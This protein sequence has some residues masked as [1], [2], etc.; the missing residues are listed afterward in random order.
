MQD[1]Y[2]I[3]TNSAGIPPINTILVIDDDESHHFLV[4]RNLQK[5]GCRQ[6][7]ITAQNGLDALHKLQAIAAS[8]EKLPELIFLDIR[9]PVMDG[10]EFL[11]EVTQLTKLNLNQTKIYMCTSSMLPKDKERASL[12]AIA[13]FLPKPLTA[14]ILND[15]L[16]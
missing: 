12:Y 5:S 7:I 2:V 10:F 9:M 13:G 8:G 11:A 6:Q 16:V 15:I 1:Q 14:E 3:K 4:K